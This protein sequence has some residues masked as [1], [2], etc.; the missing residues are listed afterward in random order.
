MPR[1]SILTCEGLEFHEIPS[2]LSAREGERERLLGKPCEKYRCLHLANKISLD[3]DVPNTD[4]KYFSPLAGDA[5]LVRHYLIEPTS[6][7][8]RIKGCPEEPVF[9][10]LPALVYQHSITPLGLPCK[11]LIPHSDLPM[12]NSAND[13]MFQR[14]ELLEQ[15]AACNVL[16]LISVETE[17]LT[18]PQAIRNA[19]TDLLSQNPLPIGSVVNFKVSSSGI[20]LTDNSHK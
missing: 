18:G 7:G 10:S 6:K 3:A 13:R 20:T 1:I 15:G 4:R 19:I 5:D 8:V 9:S 17:S 12:S 11:L 14:Q 16:Y 2:F